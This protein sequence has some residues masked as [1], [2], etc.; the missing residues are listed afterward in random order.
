M[1]IRRS[2]PC[3]SALPLHRLN[4]FSA[5]AR[6]LRLP[7]FLLLVRNVERADVPCIVFP[8]RSRP[9][10]RASARSHAVYSGAFHIVSHSPSDALATLESCTCTTRLHVGHLVEEGSTRG[11]QQLE[12]NL[13]V[14]G[15]R[16][17]VV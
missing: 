4:C 14:D 11:R 3:L 16:S 10:V 15:A 8:R 5:F 1:C 12:A 9:S 6:C 2:F 13:A 7:F 17:R